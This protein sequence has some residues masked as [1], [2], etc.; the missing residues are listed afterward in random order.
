MIPPPRS[1]IRRLAFALAL[2]SSAA[3]AAGETEGNDDVCVRALDKI[4][5]ECEGAN[6]TIKGG[7]G[8]VNCTGQVLCVLTCVDEATCEEIQNP[9][10][11]EYETCTADC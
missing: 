10:G 8:E 7:D 5:T 1:P 6:V 2:A 3:C 11:T 4:E 9:A